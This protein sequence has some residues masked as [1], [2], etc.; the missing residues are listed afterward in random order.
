YLWQH[1]GSPLS[2]IRTQRHAWGQHIDWGAETFT[3]LRSTIAHPG[4]DLNELVTTLGLVFTVVAF[5]LLVRWR[6]PAVLT[7]YAAAV[8]LMAVVSSDVGARPRFVMTAFPL[9]IAVARPLRD[10]WWSI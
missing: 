3:T 1:T 8:M 4:R 9:L 6:P 5:V 7:V 10:L 2:Y